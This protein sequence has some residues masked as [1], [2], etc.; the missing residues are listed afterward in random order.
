MLRYLIDTDVAIALLRRKNLE[1]LARARLNSE[2]LAI[3]TVSVFELWYGA[4][5][6]RAPIENR[7]AVDEFVSLLA[8]IEFDL[9][10]ASQA[11]EIRQ[12]LASAGTPIGPYDVQ[13]AATARSRGLTVATGNLRE[14]E[15]VR[16]L[17]SLDWIRP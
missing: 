4:E 2:S 9:A 16:G 14:F 5:R 12:E 11:A 3:S 15:R 1:V 17:R 7:R 8:V 13:I 10:A 6:S